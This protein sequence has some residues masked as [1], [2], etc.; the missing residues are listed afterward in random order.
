LYAFILFS[1]YMHF[2]EYL[3]SQ[4]RQHMNSG[5]FHE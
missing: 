1:M 5:L 2:P 3:Y 4:I